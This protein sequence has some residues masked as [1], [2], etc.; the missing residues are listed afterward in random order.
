MVIHWITAAT[1]EG[2]GEWFFME[3]RVRRQNSAK[4]PYATQYLRIQPICELIAKSVEVGG[5]FFL[6]STNF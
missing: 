4:N 5:C 3:D 2:P 6:D 1:D